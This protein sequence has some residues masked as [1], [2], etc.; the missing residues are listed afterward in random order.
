[1]DDVWSNLRR[2]RQAYVLPDYDA[3]VECEHCKRDGRLGSV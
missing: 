2:S 3:V 1:M